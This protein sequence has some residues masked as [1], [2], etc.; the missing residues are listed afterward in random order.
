MR[1]I[2]KFE[3]TPGDIY[4]V[5][6]TDG[7]IAMGSTILLHL[8]TEPPVSLEA[9]VHHADRGFTGRIMAKIALHAPEDKFLARIN[10]LDGEPHNGKL[11]I[12]KRA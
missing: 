4:D 10:V 11:S 6:R 12:D 7:I 3:P 5:R 2:R 8:R 1:S 9:I